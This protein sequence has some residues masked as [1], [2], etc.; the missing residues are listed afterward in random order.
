MR[1]AIPW[2]SASMPAR[3]DPGLSESVTVD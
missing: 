1:M 2:S 3:V